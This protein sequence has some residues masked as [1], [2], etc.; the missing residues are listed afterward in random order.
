MTVRTDYENGN[1]LSRSEQVIKDLSHFDIKGSFDEIEQF[2]EDSNW[3]YLKRR[4]ELI[5]RD[6]DSLSAKEKKDFERSKNHLEKGVK[7]LDRHENS[8]SKF[9]ENYTKLSTAYLRLKDMFGTLEKKYIQ[10]KLGSSKHNAE[11]QEYKR[12]YEYAMELAL[13]E[14]KINQV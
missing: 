10:A 9:L 4:N 12:L 14:S 7:L 6:Y 5:I 3:Y 8:I 1:G 13:E 11:A 2:L